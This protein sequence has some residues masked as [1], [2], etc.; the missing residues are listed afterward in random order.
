MLFGSRGFE[1]A[2]LAKQKSNL[3]RLGERRHDAEQ[4]CQT[5]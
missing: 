2:R 1:H 5:S 4:G 3:R